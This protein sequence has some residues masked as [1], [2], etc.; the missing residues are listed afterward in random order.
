[1]RTKANRKSTMMFL[2][3]IVLIALG[4]LATPIQA[5]IEGFGHMNAK[6]LQSAENTSAGIVLTEIPLEL[7]RETD[8]V[9]IRW[10]GEIE[11][12]MKYSRSPGGGNPA[13]YPDSTQKAGTG[14]LTFKPEDEGM[15]VGL[16]YC[17]ITS[18]DGTKASVE[19]NLIVESAVGVTMNSP[20]G[21][22][23]SP[24][25]V[26]FWQSNPG[27]PFYLIVVSD[28]P[29]VI[30]TVE[31]EQQVKGLNAIW[32]AITPE[33]SIQYG[34]PDPSGSFISPAPPLL[35]G[36]TYNWIV[37]NNYGNTLS[38]T[39]EVTAT[40]KDF[41]LTQEVEIPAP[42]NMY[43]EPGSVLNYEDNPI[44][45]FQWS[46]VPEA[47]S[48]H[49]YLSEYREIV[50]GSEG[51]YPV[52]DAIT[53]DALIDLEARYFLIN[54]K[55][56]WKVIAEDAE[57]HIAVSDTTSFWH[58]IA[59]STLDIWTIDGATG[60]P[61]PYATVK[62][63]PIDG[64]VDIT[65]ILMN[66][67]GH[68]EKIIATG[69]YIIT[70]EKKG[71]E[72]RVDTLLLTEDPYPDP[73]NDQ[74]DIE[75]KARLFPSSAQFYGTVVDNSAGNIPV[76]QA[77]VELTSADETV[78]TSTLSD[79][80]GNF[81]IGVSAGEWQITVGKTGY[82]SLELSRVIEPGQNINLDSLKIAEHK[83]QIF[84][85]AVDH[86]GSPLWGVTVK[87]ENDEGT[88]F[89]HITAAEGNYAIKVSPGLWIITASKT[90]YVS[91]KPQK[92]E[93]LG[94]DLRVDFSLSGN[95]NFIKGKVT[96]GKNPIADAIV[97]AVPNIGNLVTTTTNL[98]G[99]YTLNLFSGS[100][101]ITASK[102][103]YT[104]PPELSVT[105]GVTVTV[106]ETKSGLDFVLIPDNC[107]IQGKI[108][109]DGITGIAGATVTTSDK[110]VSTDD[111][112][113]YQVKVLAGTYWLS[114]SKSGYLS[115][116]P[117]KLTL[118][119]GETVSGIDFLLVPNAS[120]ITGKVTSAGA[121]IVGA[122]IEAKG[123]TRE[124]VT[125]TDA[126]GYFSVSL[127]AG[128][129]DLIA[130]KTSFIPDT[131]YSI[132]VNPG[133]TA[134]GKDFQ[135]IQY[136]GYLQGTVTDGVSPL[137]KAKISIQGSG[138]PSPCYSTVSD[139]SG[140]FVVA[141]IPEIS[142]QVSVSKDGYSDAWEETDPVPVGGTA[143]T[144]IQLTAMPSQISGTVVDEDGNPIWKAKVKAIHVETTRRVV[145]TTT[146]ARGEFLLSLGTG[147]Y[148]I[149][150]AQPGY[151]CLTPTE[152]T[153]LPGQKLNDVTIT[154]KSNLSTIVGSVRDQ[155]TG[156]VIEG[157]K[158]VA[159]ESATQTGGTFYSTAGG[160]FTLSELFSGT[161][162]LILAKQGYVEKTVE[163]MALP[164]GI[165]KML[166]D[167]LLVP[168][169]SSIT[170]QVEGPAGATVMATATA[171]NQITYGLSDESGN[172][173]LPHLSPGEYTVKVA[174]TG[175][176][177]SPEFISVT[178][179]PGEKLTGINFVLQQ[180][181]GLIEGRIY[182][183]LDSTVGLRN[184]VVI[185]DDGLG[186]SGS[187]TT[188]AEGRY[189]IG[190][191]ADL[192]QQFALQAKYPAYIT[193]TITVS[194]GTKEADFALES[195]RRVLRGTVKNQEGTAAGFPN[196]L[197]IKLFSEQIGTKEAVA[198]RPANYLF[199]FS[200]LSPGQSYSVWV[201][202][203]Q[204]G[205]ASF[206]QSVSITQ[207]ETTFVELTLEVHT[208]AIKGN[209][210]T[211][212]A[213][214][215]A[216]G[217][218][219]AHVYTTISQPDGSFIIS[220]MYDDSYQVT[221][222]KPKHI[223]AS[224]NITAGMGETKDLGNLLKLEEVEITLTGKVLDLMTDASVADV[225]V[226]AI[227]SDGKSSG[228]DTTD[229]N[230]GFKIEGLSPQMKYTVATTLPVE[231]YEN[232]QTEV[233]VGVVA[234]ELITL[235]VAVHNSEISGTVVEVQTGEALP[236]AIV[237][238][239][240][241]LTVLTDATGSYSFTDLYSGNY[242]IQVKKTGYSASLPQQVSLETGQSL[243]VDPVEIAKLEYTISGTIT[244]AA[245]G[246]SV[247]NAVVKLKNWQDDS[248]I[249]QDTTDQVGAF[250]FSGL[251][252]D[253]R[254]RVVTT[255]KG[256]LTY[257]S[258]DAIDIS[259]GP[260]THNV[261]LTAQPN[262]VYGTVFYSSTN[263]SIERAVVRARESSGRTVTDTTDSFGDYALTLPSGLYALI[264]QK[265]TLASSP[266]SLSGGVSRLEDL[267][268]TETACVN[269]HVLYGETAVANA[270]VVV[271]NLETGEPS[272]T[273]SG[274]DGAYH[275]RGLLPGAYQ[276]SVTAS[277]FVVLDSPQQVTLSLGDSLLV[278]F[279]GKGVSN[280]VSGI[281]SDERGGSIEGAQILLVADGDSLS[282]ETSSDGSFVFENIPD[283]TYS[284]W[285]QA[286]GYIG[287]NVG[288]ISLA[289][290][291][292]V[293][294]SFSLTPI[295]GTI[296][297]RTR[298][299][300]T[301]ATEKGA[302]V[303]LT[304]PVSSSDTTGTGGEYLFADLT[305]GNYA[306][307]AQ[308]PS[309]ASQ[310]D[311]FTVSLSAGSSLM[312]LDF[313]LTP[314]ITLAQINGT[315]S[316]GTE[317]IKDALVI[318]QTSD[319]SFIDSTTTDQ[320]G[321]YAFSD[322]VSPE[323][324]R[325]EVSVPG[326]TPVTSELIELTETGARWDFSFPSARIS[327]RFT[328]DGL[329]PLASVEVRIKGAESELTVTS[330]SD[331]SCN[332]PNNLKAGQYQ[333]TVLSPNR[334]IA[335]KP[336]S[337]SLTSAEQRT[338]EIMLPLEHIPVSSASAADS[339]KVIVA[340]A[341]PDPDV[342]DSFNLYVKAIDQ[343]LYLPRSMKSEAEGF[344]SLISPQ[345][346]S[347]QLSYYIK[348]K[349]LLR[350]I[351]S[352]QVETTSVPLTYSEEGAPHT[353]EIT[354]KGIL[355]SADLEPKT[356]ILSLDGEITLQAHGYDETGTVLD[357]LISKEGGVTWELSSVSP[358][359]YGAQIEPVSQEPL[360]AVFKS[361]QVAGE[362][363]V[364]AKVGL[365]N[366]FSIAH[367]TVQIK[368]VSLEGIRFLGT[369]ISELEA[370]SAH[371]FLA[372]GEGKT[373][374]DL[375][376]D[377]YIKPSWAVEPEQAGTIT[378]GLFQAFASYLGPAK[379]VVSLGEVRK[380]LPLSIYQKMAP[381]VSELSFNDA[382]GFSITFPAGSVRA[383]TRLLLNKLEAPVV[384]K[385]SPEYELHGQVYDLRFSVSNPLE[386]GASI[387]IE[388]PLP[389][390]VKAERASIRYWDNEQL[391]W[392]ETETLPGHS[393]AIPVI[394]AE[395]P[396]NTLAKYPQYA[397][398][399]ES[400]PL[401]ISELSFIPN[402][403]SPQVGDGLTI[404]Y[405]L[406]SNNTS[407]PFVT[408]K[409]Y[410]LTGTLVRTLLNDHQNKGAQTVTWD[411]LTDSG[412]EARNGR[413]LV[414]I[415]VK[416]ARKTEEVIKSVVLM[417]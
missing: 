256:Y 82:S 144:S 107:Q 103:G 35:A 283:G 345:R 92:Q 191:L 162:T 48:Y 391:D 152:Q 168:K 155:S 118:N 49:I 311:S 269:G 383:R 276:I 185:A 240:H 349:A 83:F 51:F 288:E 405:W 187:A 23:T 89:T 342:W 243:S 100:Y 159:T 33:V 177:S 306:I 76:E 353:V 52:W 297:G 194:L 245:S 91:S 395:I 232:A 385:Y 375:S 182:S 127:P 18:T 148:S 140:S 20:V 226:V 218:D 175:Y 328:T 417:K 343:P 359:H 338:E 44:I 295:V 406:S 300:K 197:K 242:I 201:E 364:K 386:P 163:N 143:V 307:K 132:S 331:G 329:S 134:T 206:S 133:V 388:L 193:A 167:L 264:A 371:R 384:K 366:I 207:Q 250:A 56:T 154:L 266:L 8:A 216:Q 88:I 136:I 99:E 72:T 183:A 71:Y 274:S 370:G 227:S 362:V 326:F 352:D 228:A 315:I 131:L 150:A 277:G 112:G 115:S 313:L 410:N 59:I 254:Y 282:T 394:G 3:A 120:V 86:N 54:A 180:N 350:R 16:Y 173:L 104:S 415:Q 25:P 60:Q 68:F 377:I 199:N 321:S 198:D 75:Y 360:R 181:I 80:N 396:A 413:Y 247:R 63:C 354:S 253:V 125:Q 224:T 64:S 339:I 403:F 67:G 374:E 117:Q 77:T 24:A 411:G 393:S 161:Y 255:K 267:R 407:A 123:A 222:T 142:Y 74:G 378:D 312:G 202:I 316:H 291:R 273:K 281:C 45:T 287:K 149:E 409:I 13:N 244:A 389:G 408:I 47:V 130:S 137:R 318:I 141:V 196:Q 164:G 106:G 4:F 28:E 66:A 102:P 98:Y 200:D 17:L 95:A 61:L 34:Q 308:K 235:R 382:R 271:Q 225:P 292:P 38:T 42:Q 241:S 361:G 304:G 146:D 166:E 347:G 11:G 21:E 376:V 19:F 176:S 323:R 209:V 332:T 73:D 9:T 381:T 246:T 153:L 356:S 147:T 335:P 14:K 341:I 280:T 229:Q 416:D 184:A 210:G 272:E 278:D 402:P 1:M 286:S 294:L 10:L 55:Y 97:E 69:S 215:A 78:S 122:T 31:G 284:V 270:A 40:P 145:S 151:L 101:V 327:L 268:L 390:R 333:V 412:K 135:L 190:N 330:D 70:T 392:V 260:Q 87:A 108:T 346:K 302:V 126:E 84:G 373:P 301:G 257:Q 111:N 262:T 139:I 379:L 57:G 221:V 160:S 119:P 320:Q 289:N 258:E 249:S 124:E 208:S 43:P 233:E 248:L 30:E 317:P 32:I 290:N 223:T 65:P 404:S 105:V 309:Y 357:S 387:E 58:R 27:V 114:A 319:L 96:D 214:V 220:N 116:D 365:L 358:T 285:A 279:H 39:S 109:F 7:Y 234:P 81:S 314:E 205:Y 41:W 170:G 188:D 192:G 165:T 85:T 324:Y 261:A 37:L 334:K 212:G 203:M 189:R 29:F 351:Y 369:V 204:K 179:S 399:T 156:T 62:L 171:T 293:T 6:I 36:K 12:V 213:S 46:E 211:P 186:N 363:Q 336:W 174:L 128:T 79:A 26:F 380:E 348:A 237:T 93:I 238:L 5:E 265:G 113:Y 22:I 252:T 129:Y 400:E 15:G 178:I 344:V 367:A 138:P 322:L 340:L 50:G 169:E 158:I 397:V 239:N 172:Y 2:G 398:V 251:P 337:I 90:R 157:V 325:L 310:P 298:N 53:T 368:Q 299:S 372:V 296:S 263:Q 303:Y 121:P 219:P 305:P 401:K 217:A 236:D 94:S 230:G 355:A 414:Y 195:A 110:T 231:D 275:I 259:K